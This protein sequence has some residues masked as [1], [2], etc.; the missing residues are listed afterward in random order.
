MLVVFSLT[1]T[2]ASD[3]IPLSIDRAVTMLKQKA[4]IFYEFLFFLYDAKENTRPQGIRLSMK[5]Q[6]QSASTLSHKIPF[7]K[8]HCLISLT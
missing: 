4:S 8:R 6:L 3:D 5:A 1:V 2:E 7:S